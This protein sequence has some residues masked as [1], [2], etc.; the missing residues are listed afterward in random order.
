MSRLE[1]RVRNK[2]E[3]LRK[4]REIKYH[5]HPGKTCV[6]TRFYLHLYGS[7]N[8]DLQRVAY[9]ILFGNL[10]QIRSD[11]SRTRSSV[12]EDKRNARN[13]TQ[14]RVRLE[15]VDT[16]SRNTARFP[17]NTKTRTRNQ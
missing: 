3:T 13:T 8:I 5:N 12:L 1:R 6:A 17:V 14:L 7:F 15:W 10:E 4:L 16:A 11:N 9:N 2:T